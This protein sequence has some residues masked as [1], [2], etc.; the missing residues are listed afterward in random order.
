M[1]KQLFF[2]F[3]L[4]LFIH[5]QTDYLALSSNNQESNFGTII[6]INDGSPQTTYSFYD[7]GAPPFDNLVEINGKIYGLTESHGALDGGSIYE[8][9][10][11][12]ETFSILQYFED[13]LGSVS[14]LSISHI[15]QGNNKIYALQHNFF[16]GT[17]IVEYDVTTST[18]TSLVSLSSLGISSDN[19]ARI[20]FSDNRIYGV[21]LTGAGNNFIFSYDIVSDQLDVLLNFTNGDINGGNCGSFIVH[22]N[23]NIYGLTLN[24]GVNNKGVIFE[25][26]PTSDTYSKLHDFTSINEGASSLIEGEANT[27]YAMGYQNFGTEGRPFRFDLTTNTL[28]NLTVIPS[29]TALSYFYDNKLYGFTNITSSGSKVY[30][31]DLISNTLNISSNTSLPSTPL[32]KTSDHRFVFGSDNAIYGNL[33]EF[34]T[35]T[36]TIV[37]LNGTNF[38]TQG[39]NP[40]KLMKSSTGIIYGICGTNPD[41]DFFPYGDRLFSFD[42]STNEYTPLVN[43]AEANYGIRPIDIIETT[44]GLI[45]FHVES[46]GIIGN[47]N[48]KLIEYNPI[49]DTHQL[50][51]FFEVNAGYTQVFDKLNLH[52]NNNI[53]Y[54]T[55][56]TGGSTNL[57]NGVIFSYDTTTHNYSILYESPVLFAENRTY[58]S[59]EN[60]L[61]GI[62]LTGGANNKGILYVYDLNT[63]Q[64]TVLQDLTEKN[65]IT[66]SLETVETEIENSFVETDDAIYGVF[67]QSHGINDDGS[68]FKID[69]TTDTFSIEYQFDNTTDNKGALP[70]SIYFENGKLYGNTRNSGANNNRFYVIENG[71]LNNVPEFNGY[72]VLELDKMNNQKFIATTSSEVIEYD[73]TNSSFNI[74][75]TFNSDFESTYSV[76]DLNDSSLSTEEFE[77]DVDISIH[78]NPTTDFINIQAN[79]DINLVEIYS[80]HG[81]KVLLVENK[82]RIDISSLSEGIYFLKLKT[83]KGEITKKVIKH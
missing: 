64:F 13:S 30:S 52:E 29:F 3:L 63:N 65:I 20:V 82:K 41:I 45:Y 62:T 43:V 49:T 27:L 76:I 74:L 18:T 32:F 80:L 19:I 33:M 57:S 44:S 1:K 16:N 66:G 17:S 83:V 8:Y 6:R 42:T 36:Q 79:F 25:Y 70:L 11:T 78:P 68:I 61:Y 14:T 2:L 48:G 40:L 37:S 59:S 58:L 34:D 54:G 31:Y 39:M 15:C 35:S 67:L 23:G 77:S 75:Y 12:T 51:H 38:G 4:P 46:Y 73:T 26:I 53:I 21:T 7:N 81:Q 60:K 71:A 22:S 5:S 28:T 72:T 24:G 47:Q 9:D 50:A 10:Y 55:K 56:G 69:K